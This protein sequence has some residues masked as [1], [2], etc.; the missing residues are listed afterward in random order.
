[1]F[2]GLLVQCSYFD[3][4]EIGNIGFVF[5]VMEVDGSFFVVAMSL[6]RNGLSFRFSFLEIV[7]RNIDCLNPVRMIRFDFR[8]NAD[9]VFSNVSSIVMYVCF[10]YM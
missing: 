1:M 7:L 2:W 4:V 3:A 5:D 9:F 6:L 8:L 10:E